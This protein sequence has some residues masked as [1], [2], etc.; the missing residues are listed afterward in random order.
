MK[1]LKILTLLLS[2]SLFFAHSLSAQDAEALKWEELGTTGVTP[3]ARASAKILLNPI[4][5]LM[6]ITCGNEG[7]QQWATDTYILDIEAGTWT[8]LET[9]GTPPV[10]GGEGTA[11][12]DQ[13]NQKIYYLDADTE[14][15]TLYGEVKVFDANEGTW[16]LLETTGEPPH[17]VNGIAVLDPNNNRILYFG[18][19]YSDGGK[20][21]ENDTYSLDL[22]TNVWEKLALRGEP[23]A[24]RAYCGGIYN[25]VDDLFV[26]FGGETEGGA[27]SDF[28]Q[29]NFE[30][31]SWV[32]VP[33]MNPVLPPAR[34]K[35]SMTY[36]PSMNR[37][38][39]FGGNDGAR[40]FDT[41]DI[42]D[43]NENNWLTLTFEG[44][45]PS[46]RSGAAISYFNPQRTEANEDVPFLIIFGGETDA[47][48]LND[49]WM[50]PFGE[51]EEPPPEKEPVMTILTTQG[52][53]HLGDTIEVMYSLLNNGPETVVD[54]VIA[55]HHPSWGLLFLM[56]G[57]EELSYYK[58]GVRLP[59]GYVEKNTT[60]IKARITNPI[61][62]GKY[63]FYCAIV[64]E[65]AL[66][67]DIDSAAFVYE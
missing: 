52:T 66:V 23:P 26:I 63:T 57:T 12:E 10:A 2:F 44:D 51:G 6:Y 39:L 30:D 29:L 55:V 8:E 46:A 31:N 4:D 54:L 58:K 14:G 50:L 37:L 27:S 17:T 34:I 21:F 15:S 65:G 47:T 36:D 53:Y 19:S 60:V 42:Y 62:P 24:G 5:R 16:S 13:E 40:F 3:T 22:E 43:F 33:S 49:T 56:D 32:P 41:L 28:Y 9:Q 48:M 38:L 18:G 59:T 64:R 11:V 20:I 7:V 61:P 67:G 45:L 35:P 1:N 25:S